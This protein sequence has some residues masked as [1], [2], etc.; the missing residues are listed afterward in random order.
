MSCNI[1]DYFNCDN[2]YEP[3]DQAFRQT[4]VKDV[5]TGD[6]GLRV[7]VACSDAEGGGGEWALITDAG[8]ITQLTDEDNWSEIT[9]Y[10]GTSPATAW[11]YYWDAITKIF[12]LY[13]GITVIRFM[14]NNIS[15]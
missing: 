5:V 12:Y 1:T 3:T 2:Q 8:E 14:T 15:L 9:G 4:I 11:S 10:S 6:V 7:F 13:D